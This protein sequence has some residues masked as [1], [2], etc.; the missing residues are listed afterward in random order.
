VDVNPRKLEA[1]RNLAERPGT[2]AEGI[3]AREMLAKL[4]RC[5]PPSPDPDDERGIWYAFEQHCGGKAT[6]AEFID[7]LRRYEQRRRSNPPTHWTCAC[8]RRVAIGVKC[9]DTVAHDIIQ[10]DIRG[11]FKKDDLV[12][13]NKWAYPLNCPGHIAAYIKQTS[14]PDG[15]NYPWAW[16]SI[17]F[18]HLK[19]ARQVPVMS[20]KGCHLSHIPLPEDEADELAGTW[21]AKA[22]NNKIAMIFTTDQVE[23]L[24]AYQNCG[25][26]HPFTCGNHCGA[27]LIATTDGWVCPTT[28]CGYTQDWAHG[29]MADWSWK[30]RG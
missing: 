20:D 30:Q 26:W 23:S 4:D 5:E 1:L 12:F 22:Q 28:G 10:A 6:T 14:K 24:N 8:G 2:E 9:R 15:G 11:R 21:P 27:T 7:A 29:F 18:D 3:V 25:R 17:R 16:I 19:S 13:Y